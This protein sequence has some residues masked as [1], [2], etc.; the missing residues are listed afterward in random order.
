[1]WRQF[2]VEPPFTPHNKPR[3][4]LLYSIAYFLK[5]PLISQV[6]FNAKSYEWIFNKLFGSG[7]LC[8]KAS[9][10]VHSSRNLAA[11]F[12]LKAQIILQRANEWVN[13]W[14]GKSAYE[15]SWWWFQDATPT[16]RN[17]VSFVARRGFLT[18]QN[19]TEWISKEYR[20]FNWN[21]KW[22]RSSK[23]T[24]TKEAGGLKS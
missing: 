23:G 13:E 15:Y 2:S 17:F 3:Y 1:M 24:N 10:E 11:K 20:S 19:V 12:E 6:L 8:K 18:F 9:P 14:L 5:L 22:G 21:A 7:K 4:S 16:T